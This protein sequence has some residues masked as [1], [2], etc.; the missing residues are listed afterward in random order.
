VADGPVV[1]R[2]GP[3]L[4]LNL[5]RRLALVTLLALVILP[6]GSALSA[7]S[8]TAQAYLPP[9]G[10]SFQGVTGEPVA[11]YEQ[12]VGKHPAVYQVFSAWGEF[13]PGMF[14]DA[15]AA[16]ARVMI[17]IT[18]ASG[19][20]EMITPAGIASGQGDGWLI[21]L[22]HAIAASGH[23]VY[24]RLMAEMDGSWNPYSAYNA[25]GSPRDAA[26]STREFR[27]AWKRVT[28]ILR[29]GSLRHIDGVLRRL[30][31]PRLRT[32]SD[33]PAG[34][35]AM[36]WVP[37]VAGSPALAGNQPRAYWPG[38]A[39]VDWVGTDFYSKF[40]NFSGLT[41]FYNAFTGAPFVFG[42]YAMWGADNPGFVSEVFGWMRSHP[43]ARMMIYNQGLVSGGP[44]RLSRYPSAARALRA[45]LASPRY[46]AFAPDWV[47]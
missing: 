13:L 41:S 47:R 20:R 24:I 36:L 42:E 12:A 26:H 3:S 39:W 1:P 35:V 23:P 43:R 18:T 33:L 34:K 16:R 29:G 32:Q 30:G 40:P 14:A 10:Q 2:R 19:T 22:N 46:P 25:N 21:A 4:H 6:A 28:L 44:F 9:P 17:H 45:A 38:R 27:L 8:A 37:Q 11:A 5:Q 31:L 15:A 7:A